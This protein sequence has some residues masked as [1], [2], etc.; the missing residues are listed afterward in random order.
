MLF[1]LLAGLLLVTQAACGSGGGSQSGGQGPSQTQSSDASEGKKE[2]ISWKMGHIVVEDHIWHKTAV[3]FAELV[4]EKTDGQIEITVFPNSQLGGEVDV[5]NLIRA[6]TADLTISGETM[7]NWAPKAAL[8]AVPY[9]FRDE[10]HMK[11][12][13]ASDIGREI[14]S[15]IIEKVGVTPLYYHLRAPRNL[16]S[17]KPVHSPDDVKNFR[18][19]V[20]NVPLFLDAWAAVGAKPQVMDFK[21]VFTALQ[22]NVIDG[23]ENP[24]D[25]IYSGSL[26]EVQKYVNQT[27][28]VRQ[29]VYVVIGN[30]QLE[31]LSSELKQAVL[32]AAAEAQEYGQELFTAEI[33]DYRQKL[34]DRVMQI[35]ED[36]DREAFKQAMEEAVRKNLSEEQFALYE[37]IQQI[38]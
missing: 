17:N 37:R 14:E 23:Q 6:G 9:G 24:Y 15:E 32:E 34:I 1:L 35:N 20:P 28:H 10:E 2:K 30:K 5:L 13:I 29:W 31:S 25:L 19:R 7:A 16:T 33:E 4:A 8:M 11:K 27:E 3:K 12:V 26:Y 22:Q 38:Q 18:I 21:E 36:V